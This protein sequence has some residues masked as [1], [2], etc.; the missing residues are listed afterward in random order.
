MVDEMS[1]GIGLADQ[2]DRTLENRGGGFLVAT[3][4]ILEHGLEVFFHRD[5]EKG[6]DH[7]LIQ[8]PGDG[9]DALALKLLILHPGG[10]D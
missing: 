4:G 9:F 7:V 6:V 5:I 2:S 3:A 1:A 8:R 10:F